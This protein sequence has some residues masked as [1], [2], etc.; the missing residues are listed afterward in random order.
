MIKLESW[1]HRGPWVPR[2]S[3]R[4]IVVC[5]INYNDLLIYHVNFDS[6][7]LIIFPEYESNKVV[8]YFR[9]RARPRL[10]ISGLSF[11]A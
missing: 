1:P 4:S 3:Y 7:C 10:C 11:F 5:S 6:Q 9:S 2:R 8:P